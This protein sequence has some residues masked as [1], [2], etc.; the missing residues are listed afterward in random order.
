MLGVEASNG[1]AR[2]LYRA[3][4][5]ETYGIEPEAYHLDDEYWDSELM[6]LKL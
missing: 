1:P 6:T 5:F 2:A 4:G 3:F